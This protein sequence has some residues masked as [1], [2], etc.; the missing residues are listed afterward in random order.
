M[1]HDLLDTTITIGCHKIYGPCALDSSWALEIALQKR[2]KKIR[3]RRA[4]G[5]KDLQDYYE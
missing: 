5:M 4:M 2:L 1:E 3:Q